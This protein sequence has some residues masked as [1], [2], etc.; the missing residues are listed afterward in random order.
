MTREKQVKNELIR[1]FRNVDADQ[2]VRAWISDAIT[3]KDWAYAAEMLIAQMG[4]ADFKPNHIDEIGLSRGVVS[5]EDSLKL[6]R[7]VI[8][9]LTASIQNS[10]SPE[11]IQRTFDNFCMLDFLPFDLCE[12]KEMW[13]RLKYRYKSS[14]K[15]IDRRVRRRLVDIDNHI[16]K[17]NQK[18]AE[19]VKVKKGLSILRTF[20]LLIRLYVENNIVLIGEKS[21][22]ESDSS[23]FAKG[24]AILCESQ[25]QIVRIRSTAISRRPRNRKHLRRIRGLATEYG[26]S[27]GSKRLRK[28]SNRVRLP[29]LLKKGSA[30]PEDFRYM[31]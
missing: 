3:K 16:F 8:L 1:A 27:K 15:S 2:L 9:K 23:S 14:G 31:A 10:S 21:I 4:E 29:R 26:G 24:C 11:S 13:N 19:G 30:A 6:A 20:V 22:L 25:P 7:E 28:D 17:L 12:S 5:E 18:N